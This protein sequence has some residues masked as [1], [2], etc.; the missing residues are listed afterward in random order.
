MK[1]R[2]IH[3]VM[4]IATILLSTNYEMPAALLSFILYLPPIFPQHYE[5]NV[6]ILILHIKT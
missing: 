4:M 6:T 3:S 2:K 1:A 5:F